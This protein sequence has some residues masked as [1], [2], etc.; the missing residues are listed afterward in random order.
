MWIGHHGRPNASLELGRI[1][2][3]CLLASST[4]PD[5]CPLFDLFVYYD[6]ALYCRG[7]DLPS[8][9]YIYLNGEYSTVSIHFVANETGVLS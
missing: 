6:T 7:P 4:A 9:P 5:W 3:Q 2:S 8:A 1:L